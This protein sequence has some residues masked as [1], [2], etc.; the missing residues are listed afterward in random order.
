MQKR[1]FEKKFAFFNRDDIDSNKSPKTLFNV[2][3]FEKY[4][5]HLFFKVVE[6]E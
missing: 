4:N 2:N 1:C 3:T 6:V 5:K